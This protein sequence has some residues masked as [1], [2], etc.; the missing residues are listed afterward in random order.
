MRKSKLAC[1][2]P[3]REKVREANDRTRYLFNG[4]ELDTET[5][6]YYYGARYFE[7]NVT[8]WYGVD[9][10]TEK[11]VFTSPYVFCS[12][13]PIVRIDPDGND[14]YGLD[15]EGNV[16][17]IRVT[18]DE[19]D[20]LIAGVWL[21]KKG[22]VKGLKYNKNG[23]LKNKV[24]EMDCSVMSS[25]SDV[26]YKGKKIGEEYNFTSKESATEFFDF[27]RS[28]T[29]V[30]WGNYCVNHKGKNKYKVGTSHER[31]KERATA[32]S[33]LRRISNGDI[34]I[35]HSHNHPYDPDASPEN[36]PLK[37]SYDDRMF[38]K[39]I[40]SAYKQKHPDRY[41][42]EEKHGNLPTFTVHFEQRSR[43]Y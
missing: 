14:D 18:D 15:A 9:P 34:P 12:A 37:A 38:K 43:N 1:D 4:K 2:L 41:N 13:N 42:Q 8:V 11:N 6:L 27:V 29:R 19:T 20:R 31:F 24:L 10:L 28:N 30:E 3:W 36:D 22:E 33:M 21:N 16:F 17:L 40:L 26:T 32:L 23:D 39:D 7:P 5:N 25:S 35:Y